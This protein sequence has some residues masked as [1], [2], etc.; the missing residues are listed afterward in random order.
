MLRL[1][2]GGAH[3]ASIGDKDVDVLLV[4]EDLGRSLAD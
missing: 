1:A 2:L 3:D 4:G